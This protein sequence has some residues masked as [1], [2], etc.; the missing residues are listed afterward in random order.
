MDA[1]IE[2]ARRREERLAA[3]PQLTCG[4][5]EAARTLGKSVKWVFR[6]EARGLLTP[7]RLSGPT[8]PVSYLVAEVHALI[9]RAVQA[10]AEAAPCHRV[11]REVM[12]RHAK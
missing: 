6:A 7:L 11:E 8:G 12:V 5:P 3:I 2:K 4:R 1:V 10:A 9:D